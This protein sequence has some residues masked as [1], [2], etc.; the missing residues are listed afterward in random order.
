MEHPTNLDC[1]N[2]D[3]L[4]GTPIHANGPTS[5]PTSFRHAELLS[6]LLPLA[7]SASM[8]DTLARSEQ[9]RDP[10]CTLAS[11][12]C[13][14]PETPGEFRQ[15]SREGTDEVTN[16]EFRS[17]VCRCMRSGNACHG[18]GRCL[19]PTPTAAL[20]SSGAGHGQAEGAASFAPAGGVGGALHPGERVEGAGLSKVASPSAATA[21]AAAGGREPPGL[22]LFILLES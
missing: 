3:I 7:P 5:G 10:S 16:R 2:S 19:E 8:P 18:T 15:H 1:F 12:S 22:L 6:L 11:R 4:L 20:L 17:A 21:V 13:L 9:H 14:L